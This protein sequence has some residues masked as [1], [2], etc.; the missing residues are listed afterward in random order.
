M[1]AEM[2]RKKAKRR[3]KAISREKF[4][5]RKLARK[6][7]R[8]KIKI[9]AVRMARVEDRKTTNKGNALTRDTQLFFREAMMRVMSL[10]R[11]R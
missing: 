3:L 2:P 10:I 5:H 1:N 7:Q 8:Q 6:R 9:K 11:R 4:K